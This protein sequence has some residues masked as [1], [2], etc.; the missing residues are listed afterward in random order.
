MVLYAVLLLALVFSVSFGTSKLVLS[1]QTAQDTKQQIA[2]MNNFLEEWTKKTALLNHAA[3]RPVKAEQVD[4]VQT[5]LLMAL[6]VNQLDL[7]G[8]KSVPATGK[9]EDCR[10]FEM[11][12][13]GAYES[14]IHFLEDFH[15]KDAL[16]SIHSLKMESNKGK[17]KTSIQYKIYIK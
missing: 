16:I 8:F 14:T 5:N 9:N 12:F 1:Y 3:Y 17:I 11:E 7:T 2:S 13:A 4:N 15:A 6:Q 10:T